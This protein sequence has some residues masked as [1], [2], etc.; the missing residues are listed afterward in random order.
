[1]GNSLD[2]S[3]QQFIGAGAQAVIGR[4]LLTSSEL[5]AMSPISLAYIGDAV[6]ELY[7][8]SH[9]LLPA[10]RI[11]D[12]HQQVVTQVKAEQQSHFVDVLSPYL[13]D[14]EKTLIR[15]GRNATT[16]KSRRASSR[17][18]QRA[19][20]LEALIG[21]LYLTDQPR[22]INLLNRLTAQVTAQADF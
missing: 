6:F 10:K 14:S 12:Y 18:Y 19:T 9:L 20:G 21:F 1:M 17:D 22:L 13:T 2:E 5:S 7:V 11:R 16:G 4:N 8:R 15:K 3:F